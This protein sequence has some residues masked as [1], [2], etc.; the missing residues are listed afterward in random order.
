MYTTHSIAVLVESFLS[1]LLSL[2]LSLSPSLSL[3]V[4]LTHRGQSSPQQRLA[5][6]PAPRY[7]HKHTKRVFSPPRHVM[8]NQ[9]MQTLVSGG[10]SRQVVGSRK[11]S[12]LYSEKQNGKIQQ[13]NK[14]CKEA[15]RFLSPVR[16]SGSRSRDRAH[17][18]MNAAVPL[19]RLCTSSAQVV[20]LLECDTVSP[21]WNVSTEHPHWS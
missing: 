13:T 3:S 11:N 6:P 15:K 7:L 1:L 14:S 19:Y 5:L 4:N 12:V 2:T 21:L 10:P 8:Q 9:E 20:L 16:A 17:W 18:Y